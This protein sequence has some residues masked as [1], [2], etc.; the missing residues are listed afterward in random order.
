MACAE[1]FPCATCVAIFQAVKRELEPHEKNWEPPS[2]VD[3]VKELTAQGGRL[4]AMVSL[5]LVL[6]GL[7]LNNDLV[8]AVATNQGFVLMVF[9]FV[10]TASF[11]MMALF[12]SLQPAIPRNIQD[13]QSWEHLVRRKASNCLRVSLGLFVLLA[14]LIP[15]WGSVIGGQPAE[16]FLA[17]SSLVITVGYVTWFLAGWKRGQE[18]GVTKV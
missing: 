8:K 10:V 6:L 5:T 11:T 3:A 9:L 15:I 1:P 7:T 4:G 14:L 16:S 18:F 12:H 17:V 13:Q 2:V